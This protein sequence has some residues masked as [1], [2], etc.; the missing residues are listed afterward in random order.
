MTRH[1][2]RVSA[3]VL[4]YE[5]TERDVGIVRVGL[6]TNH[7]CCG[8]VYDVGGQIVAVLTGGDSSATRDS[9]VGCVSRREGIL[10]TGRSLIVE[11]DNAVEIPVVIRELRSE[12]RRVGKEWI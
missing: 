3:R 11:I 4:F 8:T 12:E 6:R 2:V 10:E 1:Q 5:C 7:N 9:C